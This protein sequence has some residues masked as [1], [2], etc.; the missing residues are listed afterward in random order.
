MISEKNIIAA[1]FSIM[2]LGMCQSFRSFGNEVSYDVPLGNPV[3]QYLGMLAFPGRVGDI[4]L[5]SRPYTEAQVCSLLVYA[6]RN[7]LI[8][9]TAINQ[10]YLQKFTREGADNHSTR[11]MPGRVFF[12]GWNSYLYPYVSTFIAVQDSNF[13]IPGFSAGGVDSISTHR[14]FCN[15]STEG[16]RLY[17]MIGG[18]AMYVD[19]SIITEYSSLREWVKTNDPDSGENYSEIL[20]QRGEPSHLMGYDD[21][22]AYMKFPTSWFD[23]K[24]GDDRISW[25]YDDSSGMIFSGVGKP[26]LQAKIDKPIGKLNYTFVLGKLIADT[27]AENRVIY[28]K[29]ITFTPSPSFSVGYSDAIITDDR[30]FVPLYCMPFLPFYFSE[31]VLGD[32]DNEIMSFDFQSRFSNRYAAYGEVVIDDMNDLTGFVNDDNFD[33]KWGWLLGIK[34]FN[35]LP[36]LPLSLFRVEALQIEPWVY[37]TAAATD[38]PRNYPVNFGQVLGNQLGPHSR[39]ITLDLSG[40]FSAVFGGGLS[41]RQIWKGEGPGSNYYDT[42]NTSPGF[43]DTLSNGTVINAADLEDKSY[44]FEVFDRDRTVL[45]ATFF[46]DPYTWLRLNANVN[47]AHELKPSTANLYQ[48]G[49][50]LQFN[51]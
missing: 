32:L 24:I 16:A 43:T 20:S 45:S 4:S 47:M 26:F 42:Y 30:E 31:H 39:Q 33:D 23:L 5:S 38:Q 11:P 29:H 8:A 41:V 9:D 25:G 17:S 36:W 15:K 44:R 48:F 49:A 35:P 21:F 51:Y 40:R 3:Y 37:T 28:A 7:R 50:G 14:E 34:V 13:S 10:F 19:G 18:V 46:A 2:I 6:A 1:I 12:D 22:T 27:Y